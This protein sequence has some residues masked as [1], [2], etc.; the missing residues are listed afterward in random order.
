[1]QELSKSGIAVKKISQ[2]LESDGKSLGRAGKQQ[3]R[4]MHDLT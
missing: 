3:A 1:M 2:Y 4:P